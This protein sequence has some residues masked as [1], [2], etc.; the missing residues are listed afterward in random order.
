MPRRTPKPK[1][2]KDTILA[3]VTKGFA[4]IG[5]KLDHHDRRFD[6]V[7]NR[8]SQV[9]VSVITLREEVR[10]NFAANEARFE[11]IEK[12]LVTLVESVD[13]FAKIYAD[14][15]QEFVVMRQHLRDVEA[16]VEKLELKL[17]AA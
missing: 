2:P 9:E 16:R 14:L 10:A 1:Q 11:Q 3:A 17:K 13:R 4:D 15:N 6:G 7:E 5:K 12:T 8:L